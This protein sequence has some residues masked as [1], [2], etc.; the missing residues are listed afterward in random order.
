M[1]C[2]TGHNELSVHICSNDITNDI[3]VFSWMGSFLKAKITFLPRDRRWKWGLFGSPL[4]VD[5]GTVKGIPR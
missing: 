3:L 4:V 2:I 5:K 1:K